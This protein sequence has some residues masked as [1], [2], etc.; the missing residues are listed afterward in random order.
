MRLNPQSN[1][2]NKHAGEPVFHD[3]KFREIDNCNNENNFVG[4]K[5]CKPIL[6]VH[7]LRYLRYSNQTYY[8]NVLFVALSEEHYEFLSYVNISFYNNSYYF[9]NDSFNT[10][11]VNSY[12]TVF[13]NCLYIDSIVH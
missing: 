5:C 3:S 11:R 6:L 7:T 9:T 8:F 4:N 10:S 1:I 13:S 2:S 12:T